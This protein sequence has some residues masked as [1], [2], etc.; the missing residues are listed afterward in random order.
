MNDQSSQL[1]Q[2]EVAPPPAPATDPAGD[3]SA[4]V[5]G[6][7]DLSSLRSLL[8]PEPAAGRR[9]PDVTGEWAT[10]QEPPLPE[11]RIGEAL[12]V[13]RTFVF[14]DITGFTE[15]CDTEGEH[16]AI[17]LLTKF[18]TVVRDVVGRRGVRVAKWLGDG[19]MIVGVNEGPAVATAAESVL[20]SAMIGIDTH[21]GIATGTALLFEGDDYVGRP[22]NLA[23]RLCDVAEPG[24]ILAA[25]LEGPLPSWLRVKGEVSVAANGMGSVAGVLSIGVTEEIAEQVSSGGDAAA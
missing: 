7:R 20:R 1:E 13:N 14:I 8:A 25:L 2:Q 21:A 24:E 11:D 18:R 15:Y 16:K 10:G 9:G 22:A 6:P 12:A 17:A 5:R 19:V 23:A 3:G 4:D